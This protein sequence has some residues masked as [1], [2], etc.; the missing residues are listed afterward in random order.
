MYFQF[1]ILQ[2]W[3]YFKKIKIGVF[4]MKAI[5]NYI[6][7]SLFLL[8][9]ASYGMKRAY[10]ESE[11]VLQEKYD[12]QVQ[13]YFAP[14]DR[15]AMKDDL[16]S[17]L[18]NAQQSIYVAMYWITDMSLLD[19]LIAAKKRGLTVEVYLDESSRDITLA[20]EKLLKNDI[21][22]IVFPS[23][24]LGTGIM[25]D[26]FFIIDFKTVV[27]GSANFTRPAFDH[28]ATQTFNYENTVVIHSDE[29]AL[30]FLKNFIA[31][32]R[33]IFGRYIDMIADYESKLLPAWFYKLWPILFKKE[34]RLSQAFW[35]GMQKLNEVQRDRV[36]AF[37][38]LMKMQ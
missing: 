9:S 29:V 11:K 17:L 27:T 35:S 1:A 36:N 34:T 30:R 14:E 10:P 31:I 6:V 15:K 28:T 4:E 20:V 7:L 19:K 8:C 21:V 12:V 23:Q 26:K 18:D 33:E 13:I 16:F 24:F 5:K 3:F 22:P 32:Q 38:T 2:L 25:H 37:R